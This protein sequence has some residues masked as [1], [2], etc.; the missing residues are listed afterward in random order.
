MNKTNLYLILFLTIIYIP[1]LCQTNL[2]TDRFGIMFYNVE[3]LFDTYNDSIK[4]D[5]EFLPDGL[6][7]WNYKK[8][9]TK[10]HHISHVI[11][12]SGKYNPPTIIGLCEIENHKV[13]KDLI[14][15][16]GLSNLAY[17]II[18]F[19]SDDNRGIDCAL[20]YKA[21]QFVPL[22]SKAIKIKFK[23][24]DR[25]TR[26]I[27]YTFGLYKESIPLHI[28]VCHFPSRYG[29]VMETKDKR[30][31]AAKTLSDTIQNIYQSDKMANIL[32]MGDFN[33]NPSDSSMKY[34]VQKTNLVNLATHTT[35]INKAQGTL[36][37]QFEWNTFDQFLISNNIKSNN[38]IVTV[39]ENQSILDFKFL[40]EEDYKYTG[41]KPF[42]TYIGYKY[43]NGYSDHFPIWLTLQ[44]VQIK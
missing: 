10:L 27:L 35:Q 18:H 8:Y 22:E 3:N 17:H 16:T 29:G 40:L 4:Q 39:T 25:P 19:E 11:L 37:H 43:N 28:F 36:K 13:L 32:V 15:K 12:E 44:C 41:T 42:R 34:I 9:Q 24:T 20:L 33:D 1:S 14:F 7:H 23:E 21:N 6:R 26:D 30:L 38:N 2:P 31:Q 5:E